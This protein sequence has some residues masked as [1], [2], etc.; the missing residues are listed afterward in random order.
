MDRVRSAMIPSSDKH[1]PLITSFTFGF[2]SAPFTWGII[3]FV[4]YTIVF[5]LVVLYVC[6]RC[7]MV[8][9]KEYRSVLTLLCI[10][11]WV[12]GRCVYFELF[13]PKKELFPSG[14]HIFQKK[15]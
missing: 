13:H 15:V 11:G 8:Y 10:M 5:E 3:F 14:L 12:M 7:S 9:D 2:I 1:V 6:H 4:A